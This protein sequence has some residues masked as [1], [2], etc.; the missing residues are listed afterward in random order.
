LAYRLLI[1]RCRFVCTKFATVLLLLGATLIAQG[2]PDEAWWLHASFTPSETA[3]ESLPVTALNQ[4]WVKIA[5][6]GY[7]S[8]PPD[9]K[10]DFNWMHRDG[11]HFQLDNY[12]KRKE[13]T[14]RE[15][16]GVFEDREGRK[17]RFLLVLEKPGSGAWKV[18][19][20][21]S[22]IGEPGFS[23]LV[24]KPSGLFWGTCMQCEEFS[25]LRF[26][27]GAFHLDSAP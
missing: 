10:E 6:L 4:S 16:C 19:Y 1:L 24:K 13:V 20:L 22:E 11:F 18:A 5:V 23:V 21:H 14:D 26:E 27:R 12:F 7:A 15:L 8:L 2:K 3:Y 9:A 25:R 17:G